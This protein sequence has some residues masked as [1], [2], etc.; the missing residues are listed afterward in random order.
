VTSEK[1]LIITG[2]ASGIGA[3]SAALLSEEGW[4]VAVVD[5]DRE[6]LQDIARALPLAHTCAADAA[7]PGELS[8]AIAQCLGRLGG[9]DAVWS[10]AGVQT[11]GDAE[12]TTL[13]ELDQAYAVNVRA[14]LVVAQA[15]LPALRAG[16]G[17]AMLITA[18]NAGLQPESK[19]IA[20][21]ATKAAAI[22]L[23]RLL[24]QPDIGRPLRWVS[25]GCDRSLHL[26]NE[27]AR[28]SRPAVLTAATTAA[29]AQQDA[30]A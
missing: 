6:R 1:R 13:P 3:A 23:A 14:H 12:H 17:G 27:A 19:M 7:H 26:G 20:Y 25:R 9:L 15:T 29:P 10:N 28:R 30:A 2:G 11:S 16:T 5:R 24:A 18:S 22:Q 21:S 8:E 4:R